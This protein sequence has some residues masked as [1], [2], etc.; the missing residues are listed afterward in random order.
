MPDVKPKTKSVTTNKRIFAGERTFHSD[1]FKFSVAKMKR[2]DSYTEEPL[3]VEIEHCHMYHTYDSDGKAQDKTV[4]SGGHFHLVEVIPPKDE[5]DLPVVI[6]KSGPMCY[7]QKKVAGKFKKTM[8]PF[9]RHGEDSHTHDVE[10]LWSSTPKSRKINS[11]AVKI[12]SAATSKGKP[13][14]GVEE[15]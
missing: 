14:E 5:G 15:A 1:A 11:E 7:E 10:Y 12:I 2:N 8:V 9:D 4:S 6:C 13:V 3:Y